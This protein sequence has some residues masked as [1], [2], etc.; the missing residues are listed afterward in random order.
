VLTFLEGKGIPY[1]IAARLTQPLQRMLYLATGWWALEPGLELPMVEVWRT[2]RGRAGC[3]NRIK[4][5]KADFGL[6]AFNPDC[7]LGRAMM[8]RHFASGFSHSRQAH[9]E[10]YGRRARVARR[11]KMTARARVG[12]QGRLRTIWYYNL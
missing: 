5:L 4:E 3:E 2:Y 10:D 8:A 12:P 7:P 11:R 9:S 6:D 1:I